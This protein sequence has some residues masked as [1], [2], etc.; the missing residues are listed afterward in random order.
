MPG[1]DRNQRARGTINPAQRV[2]R[3]FA[4]DRVG[5]QGKAA[6]VNKSRRNSRR[7]IFQLLFGLGK[8]S[9]SGEPRPKR[10]KK[11]RSFFGSLFY[12]GAVTGIWALV[13][14][15]GLLAYHAGQLPPIDKLAIPK[16]PPNIAILAS[17]GSKLANRGDT[18]GPAV[19]LRDLPKYL[20]NAFIAIEDRRFYNHWGIDVIGIGRALWNNLSKRRGAMQGGSTITQQLAKN[21]FLTQERTISRKIQEAILA[22]WLE[23]NYSKDQILQLYLNRVY[24]GS[25]AYGIAAAAQRYF[26]KS[27][28]QLTLSEAAVLAGL[29]K[30]P[31]RYAPN[32]NPSAATARA[33]LVLTAMAQEGHVSERMA[34]LA[35]ANPA[36]AIPNPRGGSINYVAD[37][38]MDQL[39]ETL[40]AIDRDLIVHTTIS[41]RL[42]ASAEKALIRQLTKNG[43]KYRVSQGAVVAMGPNGAIRAMVG[44]RDYSKSQ[45]N[46]AVAAKRQ[47]GSAFK[48]IVYLTALEKGLH[49]G[50]RRLDGPISVRGWRPENSSRSYYGNVTLTRALALSLNTVAVR[51]A[52][53]M[54]PNNVISTARRLGIKS[55]LRA[56]ASLALGTSE[57][58]LLE[59]SGAY[60]VLAN[61]GISVAPYVISKV[62]IAGGKVIYRH[63]QRD[64]RRVVAPR[65]VAAMNTMM[66]ETLLTGTARKARLPG[67]QAAGKT[68]TTQGYRDAWFIGYTSHIV[69]GVWLGNDNS[70]PTRKASGSNL[71][72]AVWSEFMRSAH[73]KV[74]P[75]RLPSG[76]WRDPA[77]GGA[78]P[79]P[80]A[81]VGRREPGFVARP[82][83]G[84]APMTI[85]PAATHR[86]RH[87]LRRR[88]NRNGDQLVPPAPIGRDYT[89]SIP[90]K[91]RSLLQR[92]LGG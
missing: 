7:S 44:G 45:F 24:Y 69:A 67:W 54:G 50:S 89:G 82:G 32:R 8:N 40:G 41:P 23:Q 46:R 81:N 91:D 86:G 13:A 34:A 6:A 87:G 39:D 37:F 52:L 74:N 29:M 42:Q 68:G 12:W 77:A 58:N 76:V 11:R 19:Q 75:N 59:M 63:R 83:R 15:T 18:G 51:V 1:P 84:G 80:P 79:V 56:N 92:M 35:L 53:E 28:A 43:V 5:S 2:L 88:E 20:P 66:Q 16:R 55:K 65:H 9:S 60:A 48:P 25:G 78:A 3:A 36:K 47:P 64:A 62:R 14:G 70:S 10:R 71:P 90:R 49:P 30:S 27:A 85:N 38:V 26:G 33:H 17:D 31:V 21:L 72:V 73:S 57:V 61:G 22:L 4:T